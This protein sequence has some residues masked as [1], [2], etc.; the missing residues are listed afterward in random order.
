MALL[1]RLIRFINH[2]GYWWPLAC[3]SVLAIVLWRHH[4][5]Q[6]L[7]ILLGGSTFA[8][9]LPFFVRHTLIRSYAKVRRG[10]HHGAIALVISLVATRVLGHGQIGALAFGVYCALTIGV[11]FW[12]ASDPMFEMMNWLAFP[13]E[14]GRLP[15]EIYLVDRRRVQWPDEPATVEC[16]LFRF[17]YDN[18]WAYGITGPI[19]FALFD[20]DFDGKSPDQIFAAYA[21]WYDQEGVGKMIQQHLDGND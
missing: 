12:C 17:R 6:S 4:D 20:Q 19:T 16:C 7:A 5:P 18:R 1:V 3:I 9:V 21:Q 8:L 14:W 11:L 10:L 15:D 2:E 13:T